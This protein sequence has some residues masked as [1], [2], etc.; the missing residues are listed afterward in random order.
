MQL[1]AFIEQRLIEIGLNK[2]EFGLKL[3]YTSSG[4]VHNIINGDYNKRV[5]LRGKASV[6]KWVRILKLEGEPER[7][8]RDAVDE[9]HAPPGIL[10][11]IQRNEAAMQAVTDFSRR[12]LLRVFPTATDEELEQVIRSLEDPDKLKVAWMKLT[13]HHQPRTIAG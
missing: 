10:S 12:L 7:R 6:D 9:S 11:R 2:H 4:L 5:P 8:F 1:G 3:G 13:E